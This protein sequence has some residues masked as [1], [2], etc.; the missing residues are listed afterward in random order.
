MHIVHKKGNAEVSSLS[1]GIPATAAIPA[2][3]SIAGAAIGAT[4]TFD[5]ALLL[6]TDVTDSK[7]NDKRNNRK[8]DEVFHAITSCR[9]AH[10]QQPDACWYSAPKKSRWQPV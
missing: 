2:A 9:P 7:A 3:L 6:L 10:I 8:N 4:N 5:T 1:F